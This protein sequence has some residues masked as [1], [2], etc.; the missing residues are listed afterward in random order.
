MTELNKQINVDYEIVSIGEDGNDFCE[1]IGYTPKTILQD[2]YKIGYE[3]AKMLYENI[4]E[5]QTLQSKTIPLTEQPFD[6]KY[7]ENKP[8]IAGNT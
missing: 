8:S 6:F 4:T 1:A 7:F 5:N 3:A 2:D